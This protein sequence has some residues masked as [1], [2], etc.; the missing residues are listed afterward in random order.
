[1]LE[2]N[3]QNNFSDKALKIRNHHHQSLIQTEEIEFI[4]Q[5]AQTYPS[6]DN[7]QP[8]EFFWDGHSLKVELIEKRGQHAFN[9]NYHTDTISMGAALKAIEIAAG[10]ISLTA[11]AEFKKIK[12]PSLTISFKRRER[13]LKPLLNTLQ[14]RA[15]DRRIYQAEQ[16]NT[17]VPQILKLIAN[18]YPLINFYWL[19]QL[20]TELKKYLTEVEGYMWEHK[21]F[22]ADFAQWLRLSRNELNRTNDGMSLESIGLSRKEAP[23]FWLFKK[24][25]ALVPLFWNLG[26]KFQVRKMAHSQWLSSSG[27]YLLTVKNN[28]PQ[29]NFEI[30][31]CG[32]DLWLQ[33]TQLNYGVQPLTLA[34]LSIYDMEMGYANPNINEKF[35]SIYQ[36]GAHTLRNSFNVIAEEVPC[37]LFRTG[38]SPNFPDKMRCPR[39]PMSEV[40]KIIK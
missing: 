30:G 9:N 39:K 36:K 6:G 35:K 37:W 11:L 13:P 27:F 4:V 24:F 28:T 2:A 14:K 40:L 19:E 15:T 7:C 8:L 33:L 20:D 29:A 5:M 18:K 34:A 10:A 23:I 32:M 21:D 17:Q 31:Q 1:M 16:K 25:P 3:N 22:F 38:P 12:K 26:L